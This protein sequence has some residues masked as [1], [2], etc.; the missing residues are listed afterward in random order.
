MRD[1]MRI[2]RILHKLGEV[3]SSPG[4]TDM[5]FG[6]LFECITGTGI[7]DHWNMEDDQFE[8]ALETWFRHELDVQQRKRDDAAGRPYNPV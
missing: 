6:Q 5:R 4:Y 8:Q 1:P 7:K 3:W 2:T